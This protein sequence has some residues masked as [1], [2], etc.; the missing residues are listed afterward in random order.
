MS[1]NK[2]TIQNTQSTDFVNISLLECNRRFSQEVQGG[3]DTSE[4]SKAR[5]T[6]RVKE[7]K[8]NIGDKIS[9]ANVFCNQ[10]GA[11]SE[12]L[13]LDGTPVST[14]HFIEFQDDLT[15]G[16]SN[17]ETSPSGYSFTKR[18]WFNEYYTPKD[19]SC[20]IT[21]NYYKNK[22]GENH[23]AL[24]RSWVGSDYTV[25]KV[26]HK[27]YA[28]GDDGI[29]SE[30]YRTWREKPRDITACNVTQGCPKNFTDQ[31]AAPH[32]TTTN[33]YQPLHHMLK[34]DWRRISYVPSNIGTAVPSNET[35]DVM[36]VDNSRYMLFAICDKNKQMSD[37]DNPLQ[38][39]KQLPVDYHNHDGA[40]RNAVYYEYPSSDSDYYNS[41]DPAVDFIY[42]PITELID[43]ET[44]KGYVAPVNVAN[45]ITEQL[46]AIKST[47]TQKKTV[48]TGANSLKQEISTKSET[49]TF[50][51]FPCGSSNDWSQGYYTNNR[52]YQTS[53]TNANKYQ[54]MQ[55]LSNYE[56]VGFKRPEIQ[57]AIRNNTHNIGL[58]TPSG[59][60]I[61][62]PILKTDSADPLPIATGIEWTQM[63]LLALQEVFQAQYLYE[64]ELWDW[65]DN[66]FFD[67]AGVDLTKPKEVT[68]ANTINFYKQFV[69][70]KHGQCRYIN[71]QPTDTTNQ[72]NSNVLGCDMYQTTGT[73]QDPNKAKD[74]VSNVLW[75]DYDNESEDFY[76]D[77]Y[78][79]KKLVYGFATKYKHT[80]GVDYIYLWMNGELNGQTGKFAPDYLWMQYDDQA[81]IPTGSRIGFDFHFSAFGHGNSIALYSGLLDWYA[82]SENLDATP[83]TAQA[84]NKVQIQA[85]GRWD[86]TGASTG[87]LSGN[88]M[89]RYVGNIRQT[90]IGANQP[91]LNFNTQ[92]SRFEISQL[93]TSEYVGNNESAGSN[94]T[95]SP[96]SAVDDYQQQV[97]KINKRSN[98][99]NFCPDLQPYTMLQI[100][101]DISSHTT[102]SNQVV[103]DMS[104]FLDRY[105]PYDSHTGIII[106]D[107]GY[108]LVESTDR[109]RKNT[110]EESL[111][112]KLGFL[113]S[114]LIFDNSN[115][116]LVEKP[117]QRKMNEI[118]TL[119]T[120]FPT[121]NAIVS[122]ND[123]PNY[124][125][126]A[127]GN[128]I[129]N[130]TLPVSSI[131]WGFDNYTPV[132]EP[133]INMVQTSSTLGASMFPKK[134]E[135]GFFLIRSNIIPN[136]QYSG[137]KY[138]GT[139]LNVV[140]VCNKENAESDFYFS[141]TSQ[142]EFTATKPFVISEITTSIHKPNQEL[143]DLDENSC[144]I[145]KIEKNIMQQT[146]LI[147]D[148]L[149]RNK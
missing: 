14:T 98:F 62:S 92:S 138:G 91:L 16:N 81:T 74:H 58:F 32:N 51:P 109:L 70:K 115:N 100:R 131:L 117:F 59:F 48:G 9:V 15:F 142:M 46:T 90:Y 2:T 11:S 54:A 104:P 101:D 5:F 130:F 79:Q 17:V 57:L 137:S 146:D 28:N 3:N 24:P 112:S 95:G 43:L 23:V 21:I 65:D 38:K 84:V 144:V 6:N 34:C 86:R 39:P 40:L 141:E 66:V 35:T 63:N 89:F 88:N 45:T 4:D 68:N 106:K 128:S 29:L 1:S 120:K 129:M 125:K 121:T 8:V 97:Y 20:K 55:Y 41:K 44:S 50:K 61:H 105:I 113:Q 143:A 42:L 7:T 114:D 76:E 119:L 102:L 77:T 118:D 126:N 148:I 67:E 122:M 73:A 127:F 108:N 33:F 135:N 37:A 47:V 136:T 93:H 26:V 18:V 80:D 60:Q 78:Q 116:N 27:M 147:S 56:I 75:I 19:N 30:D 12:V 103:S 13:Q 52:N 64:D 123:I 99:F 71:I 134:M 133:V 140:A 94:I 85:R 82:N 49:A 124:V 145:Y 149:S 139:E 36:A 22:N 69:N 53:D 107:W 10:R 83:Q 110:W 31:Y 96:V 132:V 72:T 25:D 111:W 87:K